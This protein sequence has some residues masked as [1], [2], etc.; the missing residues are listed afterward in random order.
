MSY[1]IDLCRKTLR[2]LWFFLLLKKYG[3]RWGDGILFYIRQIVLFSLNNP[4]HNFIM[5]GNLRLK[6]NSRVES[7]EMTCC[8]FYSLLTWFFW[9]SFFF[10]WICFLKLVWKSVTKSIGH[11]DLQSSLYPLTESLQIHLKVNKLE[12]TIWKLI[13]AT[14]VYH[15]WRERNNIVFR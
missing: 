6:K 1:M 11:E 13:L 9:A 4:S 3:K 7:S 14:F 15:L 12:N 8:V 5:W 2:D 10:F